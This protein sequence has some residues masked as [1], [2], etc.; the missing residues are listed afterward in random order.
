MSIYTYDGEKISTSALFASLDAEKDAAQI[1][2]GQ[3]FP[4][5]CDYFTREYFEKSI[6]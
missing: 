4:F 5:L 2:G 3:L 6:D 1:D